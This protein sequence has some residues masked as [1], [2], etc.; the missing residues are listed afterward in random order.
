MKVKL[1]DGTYHK[2]LFLPVRVAGTFKLSYS[3]HAIEAS[4]SDKYGSI[5]LPES[6]S[7]NN[8]DIIEAEIES[9]CVVKLVARCS[10]DSY[11]DIIIVFMPNKSN[12]VKT[13]WLNLKSDNHNTL[14]RYN[15]ISKEMVINNSI[16]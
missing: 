9:G 10:Y 16:V 6:I 15:Y 12:L 5:C 13:V 14:K 8:D 1:L 4:K 7:I 3:R 2:D 11:R